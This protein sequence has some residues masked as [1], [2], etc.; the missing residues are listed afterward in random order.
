MESQSQS[1]SVQGMS[2][3]HCVKS[4]QDGLNEIGVSAKVDLESKVVQ[5][6]FDESQVNLETIRQTIVNLGY[7]IV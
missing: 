2:C 5:L 1:I 7:E 4:I 6:E 3:N